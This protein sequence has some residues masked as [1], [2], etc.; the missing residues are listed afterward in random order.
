MRVF[1][2]GSRPRPSGLARR[3]PREFSPGSYGLLPRRRF[4]APGS[5]FSGIKTDPR[6]SIGT[7]KRNIK[8]RVPRRLGEN[9]GRAL[10]A[11]RVRGSARTIIAGAEAAHCLPH[12]YRQ[13]ESHRAARA[14]TRAHNARREIGRVRRRGGAP[15]SRAKAGSL[16][17]KFGII[18]SRKRAARVGAIAPGPR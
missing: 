4:D 5:N 8:S 9:G 11:R 18:V 2:G 7:I 3:N 14:R 17:A 15:G 6:G 1:P 12:C 13:K 16:D 10:R